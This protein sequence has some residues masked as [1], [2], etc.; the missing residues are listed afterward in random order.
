MRR[1]LVAGLSLI[2]MSAAAA[3]LQQNH[4]RHAMVGKAPD[5]A[6]LSA[7]GIVPPPFGFRTPI[8]VQPLVNPNEWGYRPGGVA[9]SLPYVFLAPT[10]GD[11]FWA[12]LGLQPPP[13]G[14]QWVRS[15]PD[16]LLVNVNTGHI[17]ETRFNVMDGGI[18]Q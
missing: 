18:D 12:T 2:A 17:A 8:G 10:Y 3:E 1:L 5:P 14:Y 15:G 6:D 9:S 4:Q 16:L 13:P 7:A 11:T